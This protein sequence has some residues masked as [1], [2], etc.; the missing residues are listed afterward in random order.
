LNGTATVVLVKKSIPLP[1]TP[2]SKSSKLATTH[3]EK[4][5][6]VNN[7]LASVF[8]GNLSSH[9]SRVHGLQDGDWGR[10]IPPTVREDQVCDHLRNLSIH[11]SMGPDEIHPRVLRELADIIAKPLFVILEKSWRSGEVPGDWKKGKIAPIFKKGRKVDPG[12]PS[13]SV[14]K[15]KVSFSVRCGTQES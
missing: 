9:A 14:G 5:E 2:M 6:I 3:K 7:F 10:K 11:K 4:A 15:E 1:P 13:H 8:T 12:V